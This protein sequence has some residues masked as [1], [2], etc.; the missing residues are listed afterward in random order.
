VIATE[1]NPDNQSTSRKSGEQW[2]TQLQDELYQEASTNFG[3]ALERLARAYE[4]EPDRRRD[5]LQEIHIALWRSLHG[6]D[7]RCS[8]RTWIYRVAHNVGATHVARQYRNRSQALVGL[9]EFESLPD[10][11]AGEAAAD[12]NIALNRLMDLIQRLKPLDRH[13]ILSYLEGL[14]AA[15]IGEITGLS[16]RNVAT[17]IHRIKNLLTRLFQEGGSNNE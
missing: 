13:V 16:S 7:Q 17:K 14:D 10:P 4:A 5:L 6:F 15:A 1:A 11:H 2:G 3:P 9:E 8:L 12:R